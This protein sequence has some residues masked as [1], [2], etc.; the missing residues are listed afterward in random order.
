M[1][2]ENFAFQYSGVFPQSGCSYM[3]I[4]NE[5]LSQEL[6]RSS[7]GP[8]S[9]SGAFTVQANDFF[10]FAHRPAFMR[11]L[12]QFEVYNSDLAAAN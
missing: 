8:E 4:L 1:L 12:A 9:L 6:L 5:N 7:Y 11:K 3:R 2:F 10:T